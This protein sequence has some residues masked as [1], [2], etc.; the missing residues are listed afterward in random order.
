[1]ALCLL[2]PYAVA[3][4]SIILPE[5]L[6]ISLEMR[7]DL[8]SKSAK[9]G[10]SVKLAVAKPVTI[11]GVIAIAAGTPVT[12]QVVRVSDNGLLG[13]SGKLDIRVSTVRAG[14]QDI[15]VRGE[16]NIEGKP[17]TLNS[18]GAGVVFLPLAI[19]IRG[20]DVTLPA[21][22]IFDVY[23]DKEVSIGAAEPMGMTL[24][25]SASPAPSESNSIRAIDPND[26]LTP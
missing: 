6:S 26:P 1:M 19:L 2:E 3:A 17:G 12:G 13:R 23:V 22:T 16:R 11:G 20:K 10:Q 9:K 4:Q 5:G 21:G 15:A 25:A 7:Q 18:V 8:S 24:G 14:Q